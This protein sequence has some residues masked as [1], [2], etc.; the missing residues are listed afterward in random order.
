MKTSVITIPARLCFEC[1]KPVTE[2]AG[3]H[4]PLD[5]KTRVF[6]HG[7]GHLCN[8]ICA[9]RWTCDYA[10]VIIQPAEKSTP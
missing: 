6:C 5:K 9:A 7:D 1:K 10:Q 2:C 8:A 4:R 3:C